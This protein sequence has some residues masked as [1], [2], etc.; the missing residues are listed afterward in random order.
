M[1]ILMRMTKRAVNLSI[2]EDLLAQA[3]ALKLN[4][5]CLLEEKLN[6]RLRAERERRWLEENREAIETFNRRVERDGPVIQ[7]LSVI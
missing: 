2:D 7:D 5:S 6:D 3:R 4:L 1:R